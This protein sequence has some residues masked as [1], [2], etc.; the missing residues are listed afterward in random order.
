MLFI[1]V[2]HLSF[3]GQTLIYFEG[4]KELFNVLKIKHILKNWNDSISQGITKSMN[5][6]LLDSI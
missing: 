5:E 2:C 1:Y 3:K 6:L 4:L